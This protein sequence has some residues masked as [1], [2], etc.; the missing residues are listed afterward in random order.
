MLKENNGFLLKN[1]INV[2]P[3]FNKNRNVWTD[4]YFIF[5]KFCILNDIKN[6]RYRLHQRKETYKNII[7]ITKESIAILY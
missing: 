3:L 5:I 2:I 1:N 4:N 6:G 7:L